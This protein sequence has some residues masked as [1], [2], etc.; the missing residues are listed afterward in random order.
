MGDS[1]LCIN[2][3][4]FPDVT[5]VFV[6]KSLVT[7]GRQKEV[8]HLSTMKPDGSLKGVKKLLS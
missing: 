5:F 6:L 1:S 2:L 7:G 3:K 4:T 8:Y